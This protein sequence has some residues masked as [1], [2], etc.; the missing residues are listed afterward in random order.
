MLNHHNFTN[1]QSQ[2]S[3]K[4]GP[5]TNPKLALF[6]FVFQTEDYTVSTIIF[7]YQRT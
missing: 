5:Q 2:V 4:T 7:L 3:H 6:G 1:F